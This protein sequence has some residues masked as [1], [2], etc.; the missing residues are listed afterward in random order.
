MHKVT[1]LDN[2]LTGCESGRVLLFRLDRRCVAAGSESLRADSNTRIS[3]LPRFGNQSQGAG[4]P[5]LTALLGL[6]I[7]KALLRGVG[8]MRVERVADG[9]KNC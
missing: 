4:R 2:D 1:T 5:L 7:L 6:Y 8:D 3:R 9:T